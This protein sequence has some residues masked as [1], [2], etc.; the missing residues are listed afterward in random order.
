MIIRHRVEALPHVDIR[1][2]AAVVGVR[3]SGAGWFVE[4]ADGTE[5]QADLLIDASGRSSRLPHWLAHRFD[6]ALRTTEI[7]AKIGYATRVYVGDADMGDVPG[8]VLQATA[9]DPTGGLAIP[10][11]GRRWLIGAVGTGNNRPPRDA[12]GF[13]A[14][15]GGLRDPALSALSRRLQ[16]ISDVMVHR[17]TANIRRHYEALRDW[18]DGLLVMGDAFCA[19]NP[20]YGQGIAVAACEAVLLRDAL[21]SGPKPGDSRRLLAH[22][23]KI[24]ALPWSIATTTDLRFPTSEQRPP[25][26]SALPNWWTTSLSSLSTHG[27]LRAA[28]TLAG[29]YH[30]MIPARRL[31]HPALLRDVVRA[32]VSGLGPA[33]PRPAGLPGVNA[34]A[35]TGMPFSRR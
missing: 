10:V 15:L 16:P 35:H 26:S 25:R 30:L 19:F 34:S 29:V 21:R 33:T 17:Q 6:G 7:D 23:A 13:D 18:P 14:F 24:T 11:E 32:R 31:L 22:F 27:N 1:S 20:I 8:V 3:Q 5:I 9:A 12:A 2:G 28:S 4:I